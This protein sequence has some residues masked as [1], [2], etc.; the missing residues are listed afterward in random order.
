M[1]AK[2]FAKIPFHEI[3]KKKKN[4]SSKFY[5][6]NFLPKVLYNV[7]LFF[8]F[9]FCKNFLLKSVSKNILLQVFKMDFSKNFQNLLHKHSLFP[10]IFFFFS[11]CK[12]SSGS[13]L[14]QNFLSYSFAKTKNIG[15]VPSNDVTIN[16]IDLNLTKLKYSKVVNSNDLNLTNL[17]YIEIN[18]C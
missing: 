7:F 3:F 9:Y 13:F 10:S 12:I 16:L 4:P 11:F 15:R 2:V 5:F 17:K 1:F 14:L 6:F 8:I 18:W